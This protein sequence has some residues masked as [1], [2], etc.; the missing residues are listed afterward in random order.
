M[1]APKRRPRR[2]LVGEAIEEA[3]RTGEPIPAAVGRALFS[4]KPPVESVEQMSLIARVR[5]ARAAP[6]TGFADFWSLT[7]VPHAE[8][9]K[10]QAKKKFMEG[11]EAGY[12]D[13]L[14]DKPKGGYHGLRLE[15]KRLSTYGTAAGEPRESQRQWHQRLARDGYAVF[16]TWGTDA[17]WAVLCWY[18]A[19]ERTNPV[20][21]LAPILPPD[22]PYARFVCIQ[23]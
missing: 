4:P 1:S 5:Q 16:V 14:L 18:I 13:L 10:A 6:R 12:P 9:S 20:T 17:G 3:R 11:V 22:I 21:L 7:A 8:Q 15:G 23:P 2:Y 19:L